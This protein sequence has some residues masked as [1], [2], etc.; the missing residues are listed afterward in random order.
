MGLDVV[1]IDIVVMEFDTS[2]ISSTPS[3]AD[4]KLHNSL[5]PPPSTQPHGCGFVKTVIADASSVATSD[6]QTI[7]LSTPYSDI[8]GSIVP[9]ELSE[10]TLTATALSDMG[11][12]DT[13]QLAL[14]SEYIIPD[15]IAT[16]CTEGAD[17]CYSTNGT[18]HS[19]TFTAT[20]EN[21]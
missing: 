10:F 11:S 7:D 15:N 8:L 16:D 9:S 4:I 3:A 20:G 6:Y 1:A 19:T 5:S 21:H 18:S 2:G 12:N 13:I 14:V 17:C